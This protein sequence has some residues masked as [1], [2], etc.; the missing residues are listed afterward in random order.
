[1]DGRERDKRENMGGRKEWKD[2]KMDGRKEN[3]KKR[4]E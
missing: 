4:K 3:R 2:G 1:M